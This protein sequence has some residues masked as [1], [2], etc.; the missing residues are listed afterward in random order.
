ML[1]RHLI[2]V[3]GAVG[4]AVVGVMPGVAAAQPAPPPP[5]PLPNVNAFA[6]VNPKDF[7]VMDGTWYGFTAPG[8][9]TCVI[10]RSGMYGCNGAI[11]A[12]PDGAN[13]VSGSIGGLP[14]FSSAGG[15]VFAMAG[16]TKPL[17]PNTRLS[18]RTLSCG[19][20]GVATTCSD[21]Q[22]GAG[23]VISPAGSYTVGVTNPLVNRG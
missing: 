17:P 9:L 2:G 4:A 7:A 1:S 3:V 16:G 15:P 11:P 6:P 22:T 5:P 12:A 21:A 20:D 18:Y 8:G 10:Q 13:L 14:G 23:F 19:T